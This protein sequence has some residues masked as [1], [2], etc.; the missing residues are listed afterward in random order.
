ML[1]KNFIISSD[2]LGLGIGC[3]WT[4]WIEVMARLSLEIKWVLTFQKHILYNKWSLVFEVKI[5]LKKLFITW[6]FKE[7]IFDFSNM[8]QL[9]I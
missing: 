3:A 8:F 6:V 2:S 9:T 4:L 7:L 5:S 1:S